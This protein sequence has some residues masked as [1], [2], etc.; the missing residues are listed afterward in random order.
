MKRSSALYFFF[1]LLALCHGTKLQAEPERVVLKVFELPDPRHT[2]P[3]SKAN[4]AV[5]KAFREKYPHIELRAFSGIKIDGMEM[6]SGPL[7]AIAG[8]VAPDV[9]YVNF[10]QSDTYI[11]KNLLYPLDEFIA[12]IDPQELDLRVEKPVW[13]V[14]RRKKK[15]EETEKIWALPYETLV[16]VLMY[17]KDTFKRAGLDPNRPPQNWH[18]FL[19]YAKK[20]TDPQSGTFGTMFAIGTQAAYDWLPLLWAAGGDAVVF[21]DHTQKWS[22]SFA[23][24]AGVEAM[25]Y[26]L[27]LATEPWTDARGRSQRGYAMRDGDWGHMWSDGKIG[28]RM[29]YLSQ[30]NM[31]GKYDPNLYGFAPSPSGPSGRGGSE[32]NCRM[33]GIFSGAGL[34]NNGGLGDR[35]PKAVREA[36]WQ[37]IQF[38]DSEEARQIRLKV[39]I[40]SGYGRMQNPVFLERY[41]YSD[42]LRYA[43][44][45]WL[46]TFET[47]MREGR[48]EPYGDNSQKVYEYMTYPLDVLI[49]MELSGRLS[50]EPEER[51]AQI[52]DVLQSA[53]DRTNAEMI[54]TLPAAEKL[55]RERLAG[56]F[57]ALIVFA[58]GFSLWKVWKILSPE[59][60]VPRKLTSRAKLWTVLLLAPAV[61]SIFM[62]K[63][64]P[65]ISGSIMAVQDYN[66]VGH[67]P[68][69]GLANIA[70]VL[71]DAS[72]WSSVLRTLYYMGL[73]LALGFFT[74]IFLAILLQEVSRGKILY[75][76]LFYLPAVISGVIVIYLWKLLYNPSDAGA[77]NQILLSLGLPKSMWIQDERLAML[78]VVLPVV[79]AGLGPGSLIYLAALK[80]IPNELYEAADIDGVGFF[81]KIRHIVFPSLKSLIIIQLIA[82]FIVAAQSSDFI[83]IMTFGGPNEATRVA[84][85]M[86]FEKAY[87]YLRF[88]LATTMAWMLSIFLMGFT[89]LQIKYISRME[90]RSV[91][92]DTP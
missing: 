42:Y 50:T 15:G 45:G 16:R 19:D 8:G 20:L 48:P 78:C 59:L 71:F 70:E 40:E 55:R 37:Y 60:K 72:W 30:Q 81:G 5:V 11:Q 26:Y 77:L 62:W 3:G 90:F 44:S 7:L 56:V 24:E 28:M 91:K 10:R 23:S 12:R 22:A 75:R 13:Q 49:G 18:E 66:L 58:F 41:G 9:I 67:S 33:M 79:W 4:L 92:E 69:I 32:I 86:I 53:Q 54:R 89:V 80:C 82:A 85:L 88:G 51:K 74:P 6:D 64:V 68:Y 36:A 63:Y 14:I 73:S 29:D 25:E 61:I 35:D 39:M 83:L 76:V 84:D 87:L 52:K 65:L 47:A 31:G 27:R 17:R 57:A 21:D 43:P 2:D 34:Q 46:E 1:L 38:Y